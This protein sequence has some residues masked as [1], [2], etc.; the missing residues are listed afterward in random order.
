MAGTQMQ[1]RRGTA[2]Q[3][4][5][6][7][8]V[9]AAGE[10]GLETDTRLVKF[11]NGV[12]PWNALPYI[13]YLP[14]DGK[15][16]DSEK[17]DGF[18]SS[19]FVLWSDATTAPTGDK[20]VRRLSDGRAKVTTGSADDDAV[21]FLQTKKFGRDRG[22][23][24]AFPTT[25]LRRNDT[26]Y[27]DLWKCLAVYT[28]TAWRQATAASA[29]AAEYAAIPTTGA[30]AVHRGF[31]VTVT[32]TDR[33]MTRRV[34]KWDFAG[35]KLPT[36]SVKRATNLTNL[37]VLSWTPVP[38]ESVIAEETTETTMWSSAN[39]AR[40]KALIPGVYNA[41]AVAGY[42]AISSGSA[43]RYFGLRKNGLSST[44]RR[45]DSRSDTAGQQHESAGSAPFV[46]N[47]DDYVE[48]VYYTG[49][50]GDAILCFT[51]EVSP[52]LTLTLMG[53]S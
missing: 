3:W 8:K 6:A 13:N 17:L 30:E 31:R 45:I 10:W 14:L 28:G 27:H 21:N 34:N 29:T 35:G 16:K 33:I 48:L 7:N 39:P 15:A 2:A 43:T 41:T 49:A 19:E 4:T 23:G 36:V 52:S 47:V 38:F 50:S 9:L 46:L 26:F 11:G 12:T 20:A 44:I 53:N 18:D 24:V 25:D 22:S 42:Q 40:L 32:D 5:A 1:E 37:A 51:S